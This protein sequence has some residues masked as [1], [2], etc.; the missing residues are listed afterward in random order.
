MQATEEISK[1]LVMMKSVFY[2]DVEAGA[3]PLSLSMP[4]RATLEENWLK[5][6]FETPRS[7]FYWVL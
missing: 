2:A 7:E 3:Y 5:C 4:L 1:N 6:V